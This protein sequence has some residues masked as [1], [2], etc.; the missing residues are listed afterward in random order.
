MAKFIFLPHKFIDQKAAVMLPCDI[1]LPFDSFESWSK[2][3]D[4]API[5]SLRQFKRIKEIS[6]SK[7]TGFM[8]CKLQ[9]FKPDYSASKFVQDRL[10]SIGDY[11]AKFLSEVIQKYTK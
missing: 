11:N 7:E 1:V 10:E 4:Y 9:L 5:R 2:D 6:I 8:N 3:C